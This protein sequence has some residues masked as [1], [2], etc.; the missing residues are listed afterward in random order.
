MIGVYKVECVPTG[1]YYIGSSKDLSKRRRQHLKALRD[2]T[3]INIIMQRVFN[4]YGEDSLRWGKIE[5]QTVDEAVSLEQHFLS[6]SAGDKKCMNIGFS[7]AG[8]DNLSRHPNK[9]AIVKRISRSISLM[10]EEL[11]PSER[12][13]KFGRPGKLNGMHGRTHSEAVRKR[14]SK[15]RK[16]AGGEHLRGIKKSEECRKKLREAALLRVSSAGYVNP[17]KGKTHTEEAKRKMGLANKGKRPANAR[18]VVVG[19]RK[20]DSLRDCA[21]FFGVSNATV[22][23]R[24]KSDNYPDYA[25]K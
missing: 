13:T 14:L 7:A 25:Y 21:K 6:R 23:Y 16:A 18:K 24:L 5:T 10:M 17:F 19:K 3:H 12:K 8:G 4:K 2:G 22:C 9:E 11:S 1:R 15:I 20:F